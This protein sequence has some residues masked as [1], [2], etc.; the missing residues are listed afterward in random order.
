L[1]NYTPF[2]LEPWNPVLTEILFMI[3]VVSRCSGPLHCDVDYVS[4]SML[5]MNDE[6]MKY[7]VII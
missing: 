3:R 4:P 5:I 6:D 7:L 2:Q 1:W